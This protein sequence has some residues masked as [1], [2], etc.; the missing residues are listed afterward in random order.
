MLGRAMTSVL[1]AEKNHQV[2]QTQRPRGVRQSGESEGGIHYLDV[3]DEP[4]LLRTLLQVSPEI[5]I[6]CT[7][8]IKQRKEASD[9][10]KIFPINAIFP[11][12]LSEICTLLKIRVVQFS[13]DCIF[14]G[15]RGNYQDDDEVE[16][17]DFYGISKFIGEVKNSP[18]ALTLRTS[19]IGHEGDTEYGLI[20]WFL[21]QEGS[22]TGFT[23]AIFSGLP[24]I[25][26]AHVL[27]DYVIPN[28]NLSGLYNVSSDAIS[29]YDLLEIV[30]RIYGKTITIIPDGAFKMDRSLNSDHFRAATGYN[31]S[32]WEELVSLMYK[33]YP[34]SLTNNLD[35]ADV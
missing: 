14:S 26:L 22:V 12:K 33:T 17:S 3:L 21:A 18:T 23:N 13:T 2:F 16:V 7:G 35:D 25:E 8:I 32:S 34:S 29:K 24:T 31:P 28:G 5:V 6:N 9:P 19:I 20:D 11:H 30:K 15:E 10:L 27:R 1:S 4:Q